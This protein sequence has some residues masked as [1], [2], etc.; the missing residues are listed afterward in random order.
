MPPQ[1]YTI[2]GGR[3][4]RTNTTHR[5][6][7]AVA[8]EE[9]VIPSSAG[10]VVRVG[11]WAFDQLGQMSAEVKYN[12]SDGTVAGGVV[13]GE[14]AQQLSVNNKAVA[15]GNTGPGDSPGVVSPVCGPHR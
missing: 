14:F 8:T 5:K 2:N 10:D 1:F 3:P 15:T 11:V 12:D 6:T 4:D 7:D 13:I 9:M